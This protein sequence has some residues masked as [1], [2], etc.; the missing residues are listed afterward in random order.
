MPLAPYR[1]VLSVPG[2]LRLL[3]FGVLA[4]VPQTAAGIVLSLHV[5][6]PLGRGWAAAGLVGTASTVGMAIGSPW[7]GRAVD[8]QG[9]RRAL[10][11][12]VVASALV[13]GAAPFVG[14]RLLLALAVVG[15][16]L[17]LPIF[18]VMRQSLAVMVPAQSRRSAMAL[19]S[20]GVELS[21]MAGPALGVLLATQL[22][23]SA[24]I[25]SVGGCIVVSGL[26]LIAFDPPTR[27][28]D[29]VAADAAAEVEADERRAAGG[30]VPAAVREPSR[31]RLT[32][33]AM[34]AVLGA[35]AAATVVLA[36]TDVSVV[37]HLR[38]DGAL[39]LTGL[40]FAS[41][42]IGSIVGGLVYGTLHRP[43]S[44][45][46]LLLGLGLLS[47]PVGLAPSPWLLA[48]TMLPAAALCAPVITSTS[49]AIVRLVPEAVRG[50]AMGWHASALQVGSAIGAPLAG[51]AID[52]RGAWAGF[53]AV[54][55]A[56]VVLALTGLGVLRLRRSRA[57]ALVPA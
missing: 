6:G 24:A 49:E 30:P 4:R 43:V 8:T 21:F 17:S 31:G 35:T 29:G 9:L 53:A 37:A 36:G 34:L 41:W 33:P 20:V 26:A 27:S 7:R 3:L 42:G 54:G 25:L 50:E 22:S 28:A 56:G 1:A 12:S 2:V 13:W 39:A 19:D 51:A 38:A 45:L 16:V 5:V 32:S 55:A 46:L 11:P 10:V 48:L 44:P 52:A 47:I 18:T 57:A 14:Y 15:G 40:I 23:T